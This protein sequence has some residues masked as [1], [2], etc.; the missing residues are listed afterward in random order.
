MIPCIYVL[1]FW[2]SETCSLYT[3]LAGLELSIL[4]MLTLNLQRSTCFWLPSQ[5]NGLYHHFHLCLLN[6]EIYVYIYSSESWGHPN[7]SCSMYYGTEHAFSE[8][9]LLF[10]TK[11]K[12]SRS[13]TVTYLTN[14]YNLITTSVL[15][16]SLFFSFWKKAI[17]MGMPQWIFS[18]FQWRIS[19]NSVC[20]VSWYK[21]NTVK[22][23]FI[24]NT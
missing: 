12:K 1:I 23:I 17:K 6:F 8:Y 7:I 24:Q 19:F 22:Y 15:I 10:S 2:Y 13:T 11:P 5:I 3:M 9:N 16:S 21:I 4:T 18:L 20:S 14:W